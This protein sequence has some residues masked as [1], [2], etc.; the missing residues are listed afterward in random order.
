MNTT[1]SE[2]NRCFG[3][4]KNVVIYNDGI[5]HYVSV[6][7]QIDIINAM[8]TMLNNSHET[9]AFGV[10]LDHETRDELKKGTWI[11]FSFG[12]TQYYNDMPFDS[13]LIKVVAEDM[14]FNIIRKHDGIY[15]GRCY[16]ISLNN[17]MSI[18]SEAI[19][20]IIK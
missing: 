14:G 11:E 15:D 12:T 10:S 4:S 18:L 19:E 7:E 17:N 13:L 3:A 9:P 2:L 1:F 5:Q 20:G 16:Y 6:E 8:N